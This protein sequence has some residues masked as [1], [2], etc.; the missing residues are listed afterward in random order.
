M[1][2]RA[3]DGRRMAK[4]TQIC[5]SQNDQSGLPMRLEM[6]LDRMYIRLQALAEEHAR[7]RSHENVFAAAVH[8][9][10]ANLPVEGKGE[11]GPGVVDPARTQPYASW[12]EHAAMSA[13]EIAARPPLQAMLPALKPALI[14]E[15]VG[16][17][18]LLQQVFDVATT[19]LFTV[20]S[21]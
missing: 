12:A 3:E 10:R 18:G 9:E 13:E 7:R 19:V 15:C 17:P 4:F 6:P 2:P 14:F 8:R 5:A 16:I 20:G 1:S 21:E 11:G